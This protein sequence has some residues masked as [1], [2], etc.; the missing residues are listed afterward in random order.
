M[1]SPCRWRCCGPT[2]KLAGAHRAGVHQHRAGAA[3]VGARCLK[4]GEAIGRAM[5]QP[6]R[7]RTVVVLGTGGL[8]HQLDG[9]RAGFINKEF[10]LRFMEEPGGQDP[11][12]ATRSTRSRAGGTGRHPGGRT[13]DVAGRARRARAPRCSE[14]HRNYHIPIS[15]TAVGLMLA[16]K[17]RPGDPRPGLCAEAATSTGTCLHRLMIRACCCLRCRLPCS[18]ASRRTAPCPAAAGS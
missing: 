18:W 6:G 11:A 2:S 14:L 8:S 16:T 3:A 10:D 5:A 15:N 12:W 17:P 13:A 9:E 1:R 4:L 7:R